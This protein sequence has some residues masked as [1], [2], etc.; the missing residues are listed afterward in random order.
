M[1]LAR[2][3]SKLFCRSI[4]Q[5][6]RGERKLNSVGWD[7]TDL[8]RVCDPGVDTGGVEQGVA[9]LYAFDRLMTVNLRGQ[10]HAQIT[11]IGCSMIYDNSSW[12]CVRH[13]FIL[14]FI[15][16]SSFY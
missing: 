6:I 8:R 16:A 14:F 11:T 4:Q 2:A 9:K 7:T 13:C 5:K 10:V 15:M 3:I 1:S 12:T